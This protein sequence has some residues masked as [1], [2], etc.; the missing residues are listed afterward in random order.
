[1]P[2]MACYHVLFLEKSCENGIFFAIF[3]Y[4]PKM[5]TEVNTFATFAQNEYGSEYLCNICL[6]N[7]TKSNTESFFRPG[8]C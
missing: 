3:R 5:R 4:M 2:N 8:L 7:L 6:C 1:M